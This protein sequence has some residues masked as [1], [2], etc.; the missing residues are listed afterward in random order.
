MDDPSPWAAMH[1]ARGVREAGGERI[2]AEIAESSH[3]N[4][5][6][7]RQILFEEAGA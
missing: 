5:E 7:A 2:L 3:P 6:L 1:A 4:A